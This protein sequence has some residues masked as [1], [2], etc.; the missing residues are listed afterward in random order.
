MRK[1]IIALSTVTLLILASGTASAGWTWLGYEDSKFYGSGHTYDQIGIFRQSGSQFKTP[2]FFNPVQ[3]GWAD[4]GGNTATS[5]YAFGPSTSGN[6]TYTLNFIG[7]ETSSTA[8]YQISLAG[9]VQ[10]RGI[11]TFYS[12]NTISGG[13]WTGTEEAWEALGGH[14]P[15]VVPEPTSLVLLFTGCAGLAVRQY[16]KKK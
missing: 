3:A 1:L 8:L 12:N 5:A 4:Y 6:T 13:D 16:R 15:V 2:E 14:P 10:G 9:V 7:P 11:Y